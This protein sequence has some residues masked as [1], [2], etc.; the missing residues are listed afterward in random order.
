MKRRCYPKYSYLSFFILSMIALCLSIL[1]FVL[2]VDESKLVRYVWAGFMFTFFIIM[3]IAGFINYQV[4][5]IYDDKIILK[6]L[7]GV[8]EQIEF[9]NAIVEVVELDTYF[10]WTLNIKKKWICIYDKNKSFKKFNLGCSNKKKQGKIQLIFSDDTLEKIHHN[11]SLK[12][13]TGYKL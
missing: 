7:F 12:V 5:I 13:N 9:K 6:N 2:F 3:F 1:P 10:S 8:I 11:I 4:Y